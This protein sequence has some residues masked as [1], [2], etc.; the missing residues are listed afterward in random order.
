MS[1]IKAVRGVG[2]LQENSDLSSIYPLYSQY[3]QDTF[4]NKPH[5]TD[6]TV[7]DVL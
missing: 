1:K 4:E 7:A 6:I 2:A 3:V 5:M